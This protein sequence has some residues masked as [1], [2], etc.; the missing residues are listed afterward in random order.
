MNEI[1]F[2]NDGPVGGV[3]EVMRTSGRP[4]GPH[5]LTHSHLGSRTK[6]F[7]FLYC[8]SIKLTMWLS[9]KLSQGW[10]VALGEHESL[11]HLHCLSPSLPMIHFPYSLHLSFSFP[12]PSPF[13][14][15]YSTTSLPLPSPSPALTGIS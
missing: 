2:R 1:D 5:S 8:I 6:T 14:I 9:Q 7:C 15:P 12:S 11:S 4:P 10:H 13:P 3:R